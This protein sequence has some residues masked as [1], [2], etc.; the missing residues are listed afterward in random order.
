MGERA[1]FEKQ[2]NEAMFEL[3]E[4]HHYKRIDTIAS[5]ISG[6]LIKFTTH[7][8]SISKFIT[9]YLAKMITIDLDQ[10]TEK[11]KALKL[12]AT[13]KKP[14]KKPFYF[15]NNNNNNNDYRNNN[16]NN[17]NNDRNN[18]RNRGRGRRY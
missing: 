11:F 4:A 10:K 12:K 9:T 2:L 18:D 5:T 13:N 1:Y 17:R 14:K 16:G 15:S 6:A 8:M 3:I 7:P